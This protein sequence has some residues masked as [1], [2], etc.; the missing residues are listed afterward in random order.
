MRGKRRKKPG[1]FTGLNVSLRVLLLEKTVLV[2]SVAVLEAVTEY[3]GIEKTG[4][5][6]LTQT[7]VK[8]ARNSGCL[9]YD[10]IE[11]TGLQR[12]ENS[13]F[14][15]QPNQLIR[16]TAFRLLRTHTLRAADALQLS[17]AIC[18]AENRPSTL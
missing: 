2:G 7:I 5:W 3:P 1:E 8:Q 15:I 17:S 18:A 6:E 11:V 16:E 10:S 4:G 13:W 12:S 14:E 9:L